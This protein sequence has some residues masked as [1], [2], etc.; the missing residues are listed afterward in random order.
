MSIVL[1]TT[2]SA[3]LERRPISTTPAASTHSRSS[4][5]V[6]SNSASNRKQ[7]VPKD[8]VRPREGLSPE[9][10]AAAAAAEK[11]DPLSLWRICRRFAIPSSHFYFLFRKIALAQLE[12][13]SSFDHMFNSLVNKIVRLH[14]HSEE[15]FSCEFSLWSL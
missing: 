1:R 13:V 9:V 6:P 4:S 11:C 5:D 10:K 14:S 15:F 8:E 2:S 12:G 3:R 7:K